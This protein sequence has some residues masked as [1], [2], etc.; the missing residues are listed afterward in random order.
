M[1]EQAKRE[2]G[3]SRKSER[4]QRIDVTLPQWAINYLDKQVL[5]RS[6]FI[7]LLI[8]THQENEQAQ[9]EF[10]ASLKYKK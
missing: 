6:R 2:P 7:E 5:S 8:Q 1:T 10:M 3:A 4:R 9:A